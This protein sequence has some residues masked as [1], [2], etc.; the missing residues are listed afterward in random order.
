[1]KKNFK[2]S[3]FVILPALATLVLTGVASVTGT[4]AWFTANR[5]AKVTASQFTATAM[6]SNMTVTMT[7]ITGTF[8]ASSSTNSGSISVDGTLTHGSFDADGTTNKGLYTALTSDSYVTGYQNVGN[9]NNGNSVG[10][11]MAGTVETD[12]KVWYAVSWQMTF[13]VTLSS[14]SE[15]VAVLFNPA[16]SSYSRNDKAHAGFKTAMFTDDQLVVFGNDNVKTHVKTAGNG[17]E[18]FTQTK[19][20]VLKGGKEYYTLNEDQKTYSI[21]ASPNQN[22]ITT[23]FEKTYDKSALEESFQDTNYLQTNLSYSPLADK[24]TT[25]TTANEYLGTIDS[26][27]KDTGLS[28]YCVAWYEGT[29]AAVVNDNV[30]ADAMEATLNFY[31]RVI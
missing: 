9:F 28:V 3:K 13:N 8:S 24:A 30:I 14:D 4:V 19:D 7:A 12:K 29:D 16:I 6:N 22:S 25:L 27:N 18:S 1:M 20:T 10:T 17:T 15:K 26:K 11:W 2:K 31:C 21:V 5:T 23:Y